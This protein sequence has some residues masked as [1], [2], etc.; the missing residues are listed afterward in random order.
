MI[1]PSPI[2][3]EEKN[4]TKSERRTLKDYIGG[5][6]DYYNNNEI[7]SEN[8]DISSID[9]SRENVVLFGI[10][11]NPLNKNELD[12]TVESLRSMF[13]NRADA[14]GRQYKVEGGASWSKVI[15]SMSDEKLIEHIQGRATYGSYQ[16]GL[17]IRL[18]GHVLILTAMRETAQ[19]LM[20][21]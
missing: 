4:D 9:T 11:N 1:D 21:L 19:S 12:I 17:M 7:N 18:Y 13:M 6:E 16:L 5:I 3:G 10:Y 20:R 8:R 2:A 14:Y 15:G